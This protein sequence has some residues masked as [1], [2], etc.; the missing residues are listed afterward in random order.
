MCLALFCFAAAD[1]LS[2]YKGSSLS[3]TK[4]ACS[5]LGLSCIRTDVKLLGVT[6]STYGCGTTTCDKNIWTRGREGCPGFSLGGTTRSCCCSTDDCNTDTMAEVHVS[7]A[8]EGCVALGASC[9]NQGSKCGAGM[10]CDSTYKCANNPTSCSIVSSCKGGEMCI[11]ATLTSSGTCRP[12]QAPGQKCDASKNDYCLDTAAIT[13]A[14]SA[15]TYTVCPASGKCPSV[16]L[17]ATCYQPGTCGLGLRCSIATLGSLT[18]KCMTKNKIVP[19][20]QTCSTVSTFANNYE[21]CAAGSRC[22]TKDLLGTSGT[23]TAE[24]SQAAGVLVGGFAPRQLCKSGMKG[25]DGKCTAYK[26][27]SLV[28]KACQISGGKTVTG[29]GVSS[30]LTLTEGLSGFSARCECTAAGDYGKCV[31]ADNHATCISEETAWKKCSESTACMEERKDGE[32]VCSACCKEARKILTCMDG[33]GE[34]KWNNGCDLTG[35]PE[36]AGSSGASRAQITSLLLAAVAAAFA[37]CA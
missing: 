12:I 32:K 24:G 9:A 27:G 1:A 3:K 8:A 29:T 18:M 10:Y 2:C 35:C 5:T 17:D 6:T 20:G 26:A 22:M 19:I 23:C 14:L 28:G 21:Q 16:A 36:D 13:S 34:G 31:G 15:R 33:K 37:L 7:C 11:G 25:I 4:T 30:C